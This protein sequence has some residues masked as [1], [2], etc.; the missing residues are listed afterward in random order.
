[1]KPPILFYLLLVV[2]ASS[3]AFNTYTYIPQ[4]PNPS[5]FSNAEQFKANAALGRS[6]L[7]AQIAYSPVNHLAVNGGAF[8]GEHNQLALEGGLT[9]YTRL[10]RTKHLFVT[11]GGSLSQGT[12]N[13]SFDDN[14]NIN[15]VDFY[16]INCNYTGKHF[17]YGIYWHGNDVYLDREHNR[18]TFG[19]IIKHS[20]INYENYSYTE[21]DRSFRRI[22]TTL[23]AVNRT[24][25]SIKSLTL[26][27]FLENE[28]SKYATILVQMGLQPK[29]TP[30]IG[31]FD[32]PRQQR[33]FWLPSRPFLNIAFGIKID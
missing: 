7:E 8:L 10:I 33:I 27:A 30:M 14:K 16:S 29:S 3:C 24:Q 11:A 22:P 25:L 17:Q 31:L 2:F 19:F 5:A 18:K 6:H 28:I 23:N 32:A 26:M 21:I 4:M 20:Y 12:I 9:A 15:G 13:T 1:M